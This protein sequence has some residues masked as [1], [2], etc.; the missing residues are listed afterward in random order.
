MRKC[1]FCKKEISVQG[2]VG[3]EETC[4]YCGYDLHCCLNCRFYDEKAHNKCLEPTADWVA[5]KE[6][7]N[8]CEFFEF[9]GA[10]DVQEKAG[11]DEARARFDA[12]FKRPKNKPK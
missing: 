11:K 10:L 9:R 12:L 4:P 2:T 5:N 7:R 1:H 6:I 3:R 8:F